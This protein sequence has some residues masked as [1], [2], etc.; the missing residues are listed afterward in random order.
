MNNRDNVYHIA[1]M[2]YAPLEEGM[3]IGSYEVWP[4]QQQA[5][6]RIDDPQVL[7]QLNKYFGR[8][9][10]YRYEQRVGGVDRNI[11]GIFLISPK[12]FIVGSDQFTPIQIQDIQSIGHII[13]F[14]SIFE[15]GFGSITTDPF[16]TRIQSFVK[17]QEGLKVWHQ[18]YTSYDLIKFLKP[19][20]IDSPLFKYRLT[21]LAGALG[22]ALPH[23]NTNQIIKRVLRSLELLFH[24]VTFGD[25]LTNE[26]RLLTLVMA[27]EVLLN[28]E[29][30]IQFVESL[31]RYIADHEPQIL[32]RQVNIP[33][34]GET[35]V[36]KSKTCW[37]AYDLYNLRSSIIHGEDSD[38]QLREYG[39]I[40][41]RIQFS[42]LLFKRLFKSLL[43]QE[44][45]FQPNKFE[46]IIEAYSMDEA[47]EKL[48]NNFRKMNP[49]L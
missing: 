33:K 23:R 14:S 22:D 39:D 49:D 9:F 32:T 20:H 37:W 8:F 21:H 44:S 48:I 2:P 34:K 29:N 12:N 6:S 4:F 24:T 10:E 18:F 38:W 16:E 35:E 3:E 25:M 45:I 36:S 13:A 47:L 5:E 42:G 26:H 19:L 46:A 41:T 40:W 28:F 27:F 11:E 15:A 43:Q 7:K 17:G 31:E 30:K 1:F